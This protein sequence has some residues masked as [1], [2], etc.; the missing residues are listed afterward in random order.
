M[1]KRI[2][3][4]TVAGPWGAAGAARQTTTTTSRQ[5]TTEQTAPATMSP[6]SSGEVATRPATTTFRGDTGLWMVPT[7]EVLPARKGSI[8]AYRV[9]FDDNQ[10]FTDV[11]NWPVTFGIGVGD[12]AG[13]FGAWRLVNRIDRDIRP[14]FVP[15]LP[16]AGGR[17]PPTRPAR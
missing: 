1:W 16:A 9:N 14:L 4:V 8:S 3:A 13:I 10:G 12:R 6:Q 15:T 17:V 11:S 7:G 2:A 5:T